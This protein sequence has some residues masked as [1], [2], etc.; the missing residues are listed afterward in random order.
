MGFA[1]LPRGRCARRFLCIAAISFLAGC[2]TGLRPS[3]Q[4]RIANSVFVI[5]G[6]SSGL[7]Q[8]VA[9]TL[10]SHG[11]TVVLAA[12][13]TELLEEVAA[14]VRSA[15]GAS[16]V[17]TTDVSDAAAVQRLG[18]AAIEQFGRIDVWINNAGIIAIGRFWE[19]PLEDHA[20][21]IDVNLTGAIYGSHVA[22][23]QFR[24][25]GFGTLVNI[26]S[27]LG[28]LPVANQAS[29]SASKAGLHSLGAALNEELRL[30]GL[31][32]I[33]VATVMP[34]AVD[35]PVWEHAANYSGSR[36]RMVA[37]DDAQKVVDA[38]VWTALHPRA[39]RP[40][41][42]KARGAATAARFFPGIATRMASN[43]VEGQLEI[44]PPA[45][46][47]SGTLH[48]PMESGRTVA[49]GVRE[50]M[51]REDAAR[52]SRQGAFKGRR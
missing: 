46:A 8:G 24:A 23:R 22:L 1:R 38:I 52:D 27:V 31:K 20:R 47:T 25:Q 7:G 28:E 19:A 34:W 6:A 9:L 39:T 26:G 5:T 13:R 49:G 37:M 40:V 16:L 14:E 43:I 10:A 17:V 45:P 2:A 12:R 42:W 32:D 29:Y 11:A 18:E 48:E 44:A 50:R 30:S 51:E 21:V 4:Q 35:T 3:D 15:G 33:H 41:G 36:P